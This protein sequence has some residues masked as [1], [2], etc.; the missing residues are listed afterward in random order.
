MAKN[1][2]T[3]TLEID[4][5]LGNLENK[6][7]GVKKAMSGV[8]GSANA[9]KGLEKSFEKVEG[10]LERIKTKA[11]QPIDSKTGFSSIAKDIDSANLALA[12][13]LKTIG[14][15]GSMS[16]S[17]L[18]SFL[19]ADAQKQINSIIT[20][21]NNYEKAIAEAVAETTELVSVRNE[22][23]KTEEK[24][25]QA[26]SKVETK[27]HQLESAKADKKAAEE[28]IAAIKERKAELAELKAE[29]EKI[30]KFYATPDSDGKK[31]NQSKKYDGISMRPQDIRKKVIEL[32]GA[33]AGDEQ[34]L[35][36]WR[37]AL[38][39]AKSDVSSY[40][41]QLQTAKRELS[42]SQEL[43]EQLTKKVN[44]LDS[45]F[46]SDSAKKQQK[47]FGVLREEANKLG[48]SLEGI[49]E[50]YSDADAKE[51]LSRLESLKSKGL[52]KIPQATNKATK[53]IKDFGDQCRN[54]KEKVVEATES[55]EGLSEAASQ[56]KAFEDKI[57]SFLGVSGAA[58]VMR[59]ALRDA[60][61][62]IT[63]LDATMTEMAVVT[64]LSVGD[65]WDQLPE[66]SKRAS[67]LGVS[68]NS[69]YKA[70]TLYYQQGLKANEVTAIST[71]T[72]KMAKI[73][74]L[75]AAEATDKM[76]AALRGFNME[77]NETSA[78]RVSD[79]Y[80][81]LAAITAA[82]VNE[83][84]SAMTK[85]ASI[86][87][88]AG[89][90]FETTAALLS[91][92]IETTR[93][94]AETAGTAMK[95]VIAR[96]QELKKSPDE[97]GEIDGEIVDANAI[98]TALRS[99]GVSLRDAGGQFRELDEVFLE[100]SSKWN[101]LD[102]NTQRYI[103]TIAAG[104]RQQS[105]FIAMMSDYARTQE[106]VSAANNSAGASQRQF[107]K[108]M[109][110]LSAKV[111][112]LK[113]AWHEFTMGIM[114]SEL[115]KTGVDVLTKF[116]EIINKATS[117]INGLGASILKIASVFTIFK[118]GSKIFA[119]FKQ[120]I[121]ALF[122]EIVKQASVAGEKSAESFR[123]G[124]ERNKN[125]FESSGQPK[126]PGEQPKKDLPEGYKWDEKGRLHDNKGKFVNA[127]EAK[128][129]NKPGE[130]I[131]SNAVI[132]PTMKKAIDYA[133]DKTGLNKLT[134]GQK[135]L[136][137]VSEA[138]KKL[139]EN[140]GRRKKVTDLENAQSILRGR[141][142]NAKE[143]PT[144]VTP[145][146]IKEAEDNVKKATQ[147]LQ[148]YDAE[149]EK[150]T[151]QSKQGWQEIGEGIGSAGQALT[152][153]GVGMSMVGGLLSAMGLEEAGDTVSMIGQGI[154]FVGSALSA[155]PPLIAAITNAN[156]ILLAISAALAVILVTILAIASAIKKNSPEEK[157]KN[158]QAA[159]DRA[160]EA[161]NRAAESYDNLVSSLNGLDDGYRALENLIEGTKEWNEAIIALNN[162]VLDLIDTYPE[163]AQFVEH[164]DNGLLTLDTSRAEV[165]QVIQ[166][167][168]QRAIASKNNA[169]MSKIEVAKAQAKVD[170]NYDRNEQRAIQ[171]QEEAAYVAMAA[172]SRS[173]ANTGN[174]SDEQITR[175]SN[176]ADE[177]VSKKHYES[178]KNNINDIDFTNDN[179]VENAGYT[180][181]L[182]QAIQQQ[183]GEDA[184]IQNGK[185][186]YYVDGK[187]TT[188]TLTNDEI[189]GLIAA[190][191]ATEKTTN[192]FEFAEQAMAGAAEVFG[193]EAVAA[194]Y[195]GKEGGAL[196][197]EDR[198]SLSE[199][200]GEFDTDAWLKMTSDEKAA[201]YGDKKLPKNI[202]DAWEKMGDE[203]RKA[204]GGDI[205]LFIDD[206][207]EGVSISTKAF[208][209]AEETITKLGLATDTVIKD[210]MTADMASGFA[211]KLK[212]VAEKSG[213][214]GLKSVTEAY[215]TI[216]A[217]EQAEGHEEEITSL[218]NATDWTNT[219]S[220]LALQFELQE[221]Y[222]YST[223]ATESFIKTL[224][225]A[226]NATSKID[227]SSRVFGA[228]YH[229]VQKVN[230]AMQKLKDLQWDYERSIKG[231]A[232]AVEVA[233]NLEEQRQTL[234][235][236]GNEALTSY[237]AARNNQAEIF[238]KGASVVRGEDLT[239]YVAYDTETG[240]Y[241]YSVLQDK[242]DSMTNSADKEAATKWVK[243]L[244][245]A[246]KLSQ[247]QLDI[248]KDSYIQLEQLNEASEAAYYAMYEEVG[249]LII[250]ELEKEISIQQDV[251]EA[252]KTANEKLIGK[253][254]EQINSDRQERENQKTEQEISDLQMQSVYLGMNTSGSTELQKMALDQQIADKEQEYQDT[255]VDQSIQQLQDAN[256]AAA[257]QRERQI[258]LA[259]QQLEAYKLSDEYQNAIQSKLD[260]Y[261]TEYS[262]NQNRQSAWEQSLLISG[263][264]QE[265]L[266]DAANLT[267]EEFSVK[268]PEL[269]R[270]EQAALAEIYT[271]S[272]NG[273]IAQD[274]ANLTW[275]E[276]SQKYPELSA[277]E[278]AELANI[279][280]SAENSRL[281]EEGNAMT[282]EQYQRAEDAANM[283]FDDYKA[284]YSN[285]TESEQEHLA[286]V[287]TTTEAVKAWNEKQS[288]TAEEMK[289]AQDA[290][291][292]TWTEFSEAYPGMS[293][294]EQAELA[295]I[296]GAT[297]IVAGKP[298]PF[299]P[300]DTEL[301]QTMVEAGFTAGMSD[302]E[303]EDFWQNLSTNTGTAAFYAKENESN[304]ES[305]ASNTEST[306][307]ESGV[308]AQLL[309]AIKTN[310]TKEAINDYDHGQ[311]Y[312]A[313]I[314]KRE[315]HGINFTAPK[316]Y[317]E[318]GS[319][320]LQTFAAYNKNAQDYVN[321]ETSVDT[322]QLDWLTLH[323]S[324]HGVELEY[325]TQEAY[326]NK[327]AQQIAE[328]THTET[329]A[330]YIN[331]AYQTARAKA[332]TAMGQYKTAG[333]IGATAAGFND[334]E[335]RWFD[336]TLWGGEGQDK[337]KT[338]NK[339]E[340]GS[341]Y[342]NSAELNTLWEATA[343]EPMKESGF[344]VV[345]KDKKLYIS[346]GGANWYEVLD[347]GANL[348]SNEEN[349]PAELI[350]YASIFREK[351]FRQYKTGGLAD[352]TGPAWLDGTPSKPEY[353]LNAS[354]TERFFTL[355]DV[356]EGI[357]SKTSSEK[358]SGDNYFDI[359]INVDKI[360][361]DY[362]V[363]QMANKIRG[364]IYEDASYRNVNA[365]NLIR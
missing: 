44:D 173:L 188:D 113:N 21:L 267:W 171:S 261:F 153:V 120:P 264:N 179:K 89:M 157:L 268:Y 182:E 317:N 323:G 322:N 137:E 225:L 324:K 313:E 308:L 85:T 66:Y 334:K 245:E 362:D 340:T 34:A 320:N 259:E 336:L 147:A 327:Y 39:A 237:Q 253:I 23:V 229:A 290:A 92:I 244:E 91:Q 288:L 72:L 302:K 240:T 212:E 145:A 312:Q 31:R 8:L 227:E 298:D 304:T 5:E 361:S 195:S 155:L 115:V 217:S 364:I 202:T 30:E 231:G 108:T 252:T 350:N 342:G 193:A 236:Q 56:Q 143:S 265:Q 93:E 119:A 47:A 277:E 216:L 254:Q 26:Q 282:A 249:N 205:R 40:I 315:Q 348:V 209:K 59:H 230:I 49:G 251:L 68:I 306:N 43:Y 200:L 104:S 80:S 81:E 139:N 109:D 337:S 53:G 314:E 354:Q 63:E 183:Y 136:S 20:S 159:S 76:T 141:K 296:Y 363:E 25:A 15:I 279:Y 73:A 343:T 135:T 33:T 67:E 346:K 96:F 218:I 353:I 284:K 297:N 266:Q 150:L 213:E 129:Y 1:K 163:L 61:Q 222:G 154:V 138:R 60:M 356:L 178:A 357:D 100:L 189:K 55:F 174:M 221:E 271:S 326:R 339:V 142:Q 172:S 107:E 309:E 232:D 79:V 238:A 36:E 65:Y 187:E 325:T 69:A 247:D 111:E 48:V 90:E 292:M 133:K 176:L 241:D 199:G 38:K 167:A 186:T 294:A 14:S 250:A 54:T 2:T 117:G 16:E 330:E 191:S 27:T 7:N 349:R 278:Q 270:E 124:V 165:Q 140:G 19:P 84:S 74:G 260:A 345:L 82:D 62:T 106:L 144:I 114:D 214:K 151:E 177:D 185:V 347:Q 307:S 24:L 351:N 146:L 331:S 57:K 295:K 332:D 121:V 10:L 305:T 58:Q 204:F 276:F 148:E 50:S 355:I 162:N 239:Q 335:D 71:E 192:S 272:E 344:R 269:S 127:E 88:S 110:S 293:E 328:G 22:L 126:T 211:E 201:M 51:L 83:I 123:Q 275:E 35:E 286:K 341:K 365:I 130:D 283:S 234:F 219:E 207:A 233:T 131:N 86:A 181:K 263:Y 226:A 198:D 160:S 359:E 291:N 235:N 94:S 242:I 112:K 224:G 156:P 300:A 128:Q 161:A 303:K 220:L 75:D 196:T 246:N 42:D 105:R 166:E 64:D 149:Q 98:E 122:G 257:E 32:E 17:A 210:F 338:D 97:I 78:K 206:L 6:L 352:F 255:L 289:V 168:Q 9:P 170:D 281:W 29:Q 301:G 87:S 180:D 285:A 333:A 4:A 203:G 223:E 248:A 28:A 175:Y 52:A 319:S 280:T 228:F 274:A 37:E 12:S 273:R 46:E 158:T 194:L 287:Y 13:M 103:A 311:R 152:G 190:Q 132:S 360:E 134:S 118:L 358:P 310:T 258:A 256:A 70:A 125:A 169:I 321:K 95:T 318:N 116:L 18:I 3:Y 197:K 299:S 102:K 164:G 215:D 45:A 101:T 11:S 262:E 41:N 184:T 243:E 316:E 329:F 208:N 99:V 77:L